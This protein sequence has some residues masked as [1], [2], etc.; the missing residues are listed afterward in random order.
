MPPRSDLRLRKALARVDN[1]LVRR[2]GRRYFELTRDITIFDRADYLTHYVAAAPQRKISILDVGCGSSTAF[3]NFRQLPDRIASYVG[4]D[5]QVERAQRRFAALPFA[6][7]FHQVELDSEWDFGTFDL[8]ACLEVMEHLVDDRR[9]FSKLCDHVA[10]G[11]RLLV[12]TPSAPFV[13]RMA[14]EIPGFDNV[15]PTQDGDHVRTGYTLADFQAMAD[16]NG[17]EILSVDWLS[18]FDVATMRRL[19][20]MLGLTRRMLFNLRYRRADPADARVIGGDP[21]THADAYWSIGVY[22]R[23]RD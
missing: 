14:G 9:L 21:A 15:S 7:T 22:M 20:P 18:R 8:V 11:G 12:S 16:A 2:F 23:R 5:H 4:I 6:R 1:A 13:A 10:P 3:F 19:H 17:M